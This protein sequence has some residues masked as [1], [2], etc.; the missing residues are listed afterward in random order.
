ME[1]LVPGLVAAMLAG[2]AAHAPLESR[3]HVIERYGSIARDAATVALDE[4]ESSLFDGQVGRSET[5]LTSAL[6]RLIRE[7]S[8]RAS[9]TAPGA[10]DHGR[11]YCLMQ[12]R[13]G[14]GATR[15]GWSGK[16]LIEDR[17]RCFRA[18]L[19]I[20]HASFSACHSLA[21]DDRL[22]AYASGHCFAAA[23][24]SRSRVVRA[25]AWWE[26]HAS[27]KATA[28]GDLTGATRRPVGGAERPRVRHISHR[29]RGTGAVFRNEEHLKACRRRS[30]PTSPRDLDVALPAKG[31]SATHRAASVGRWRFVRAYSTTFLVIAS[32][33]WFGLLG[34]DSAEPGVTCASATYT[35]G[36]R[37]AST[38]RSCGYRASSSR[39]A[40]CSRLYESC[41]PSSGRSSKPSR[42]KSRRGRS[43][44]SPTD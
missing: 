29:K 31:I 12:I 20:L 26:A 35:C 25:R 30:L 33:M 5:V 32:Y 28:T 21:V 9:T 43:M 27:P 37:G 10:G 3:D 23:R 16:Q 17:K 18:A 22:S 19:H 38:R 36:T 1:S 41:P 4:N 2:A 8:A 42:I 15:E 6:C 11:S 13:V 34:H 14:Q 44:R 24:V 39:S 40:S 7:Y